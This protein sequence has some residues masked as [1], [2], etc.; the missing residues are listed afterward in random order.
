MIPGN[1]NNAQDQPFHEQKQGKKKPPIAPPRSPFIKERKIR[2]KV[3]D[4]DIKGILESVIAR[5]SETDLSRVSEHKALSD[6]EPE[7][8]D[9]N[10]NLA[11][12][13]Y[14]QIKH[15]NRN[16]MMK[17]NGYTTTAKNE[18]FNIEQDEDKHHDRKHMME[19]NGCTSKA[20]NEESYLEQD[21]N[22]EAV[23]NNNQH[24]LMGFQ[25]ARRDE[26]W[27][28]VRNASNLSLHKVANNNK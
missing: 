28:K 14:A 25:N 1:Q 18:E 24:E 26:L 8:V 16:H 11:E 4:D 13:I 3:R 21:E 22:K 20:E 19:D 12:N 15:H 2:R 23:F 27:N 7:T 6:T 9:V 5:V 17:E 10:Q